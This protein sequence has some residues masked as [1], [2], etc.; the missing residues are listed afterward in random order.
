MTD[1]NPF[2]ALNEAE[3]TYDTSQE[4]QQKDA[5]FF[6][7]KSLVPDVKIKLPEAQIAQTKNQISLLACSSSYG[8]NE[9]SMGR[10]LSRTK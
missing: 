10:F 7:I 3:D 1:S 5:S 2:G 8:C 9:L 6:E 4:G